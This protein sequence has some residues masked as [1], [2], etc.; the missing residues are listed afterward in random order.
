[1]VLE[2]W[3]D[4]AKWNDLPM[5]FEAGTPSIADA[6]GLGAAVDYLTKMGMDNIRRHEM[7]ITEYALSRL[8]AIEELKV[9]GV[10]E[11]NK[12]GGVISFYLD[13]LHPHDLGTFLDRQGIAVRTGHH[14]TMPI[15]RILGVPATVRTSFYLYNTV[16]EVDSLVDAV[17]NGL[18]YFGH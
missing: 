5:K 4:R 2:V 18:E 3:L 14:C 7:E 1:M 11:A 8:E 15:M 13:G 6:I 10:K 17:Q 16:K 12:R 9:F